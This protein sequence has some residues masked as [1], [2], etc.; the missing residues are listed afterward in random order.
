MFSDYLGY[1]LKPLGVVIGAYLL[2]KGFGLEESM[3]SSFSNLRIS[4]ERIGF[5]VYL[6]AIPVLVI[7]FW[8]GVQE[9]SLRSQVLL[10]TR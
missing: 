10:S 3:L 1:G 8:L 7:S 5:M 4:F 2:L 9:Y 6:A